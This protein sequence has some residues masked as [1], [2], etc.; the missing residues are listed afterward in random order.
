MISSKAGYSHLL[1]K[2]LF[3]CL[4]SLW[5]VLRRYCLSHFSSVLPEF[6]MPCSCPHKS[7]FRSFS[8]VVYGTTSSVW[9][10]NIRS[11]I[12]RRSLV[13]AE[14]SVHLYQCLFYGTFWILLKI[15]GCFAFYIRYEWWR[16]EFFDSFISMICNVGSIL[17]QQI[18]LMLQS[19]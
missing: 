10:F 5:A 9:L 19:W 12:A 8:E 16:S 4:P 15:L 13:R 2:G 18:E 17:N 11:A 14:S 1:L 6:L 3:S 7:F